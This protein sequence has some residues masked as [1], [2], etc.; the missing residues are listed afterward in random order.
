MPVIGQSVTRVDAISKVTGEALYPGDINL[1]DQAYMKVLFA[2][3]PHAIIKSIDTSQA[4]DPAG[5]SGSLYSKR[6]A[7]E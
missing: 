7:G 1:P 2:K 6:C 5:G 3:R 4:D